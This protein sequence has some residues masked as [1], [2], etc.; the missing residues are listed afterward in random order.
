[1]ER[2]LIEIGRI[3]NTHGIKGELKLLPHE[4]S[5][6]DLR[7]LSALF[8]D[9]R[10]RKIRSAR[11]HKGALLVTLEGIEDMNAALELKGRAAFADADDPGLPEGFVFM[12][13]LFG[14][15]VRTEEGEV[16]GTLTDVR[17][18]ATDIYTLDMNGKEVLFPAAEGVITAVNVEEGAITVSKK[19]FFEV[20][21]L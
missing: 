7:G 5:P 10:E 19:R 13:E 8:V 3:V 1:M 9:G 16:L 15:T 6:E 2:E 18:A 11:V 21:V 14:C 20:A 17:G 12:D 4:E